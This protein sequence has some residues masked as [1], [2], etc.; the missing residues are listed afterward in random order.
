MLA[1]DV[2]EAEG[3]TTKYITSWMWDGHHTYVT[4]DATCHVNEG[5]GVGQDV[6]VHNSNHTKDTKAKVLTPMRT[7]HYGFIA[8]VWTA[9][10]WHQHWNKSW[11]YHGGAQ[12]G[13][14]GSYSVTYYG[15]PWGNG[16]DLFVGRNRNDYPMIYRFAHLETDGQFFWQD[17]NGYFWSVYK[18]QDKVSHGQTLGYYGNTG[19]S[20]GQHLHWHISVGS[21]SSRYS[22]TYSSID[23]VGVEYGPYEATYNGIG[24]VI[25]ELNMSCW[26]SSSNNCSPTGWW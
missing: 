12:S 23:D 1:A 7:G 5:R 22:P 13:S 15:H 24:P 10:G 6:I 17:S 11:H 20:C 21:D 16:H 8:N 26:V 18:S 14:C 9:D 25:D 3:A 4:C 2:R 19:W